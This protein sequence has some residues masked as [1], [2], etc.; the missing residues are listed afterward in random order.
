MKVFLCFRKIL[1]NENN[2]LYFRNFSTS[3][4]ETVFLKRTL[5]VFNTVS[6]D[7]FIFY[8]FICSCFNFFKW[9]WVF[10]LLIAFVHFTIFSLFVNTSF[11]CCWTVTGFDRAVFTLRLFLPYTPSSFYQGFPGAGSSAM[12]VAGLPI[13]LQITYSV[14]LFV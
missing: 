6:L 12:K 10:S 7:V 1:K 11:L 8:A 14:H 13:E 9:F 5:R 2:F 3:S 4:L